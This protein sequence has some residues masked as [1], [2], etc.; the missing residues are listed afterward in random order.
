MVNNCIVLLNWYLWSSYLSPRK[1]IIDCITVHC[2]KNW[3]HNS[4][5]L[6]LPL[7]TFSFRV[8]GARMLSGGTVWVSPMYV[9]VY[10][11]ICVYIYIFIYVYIYKYIYIYIYIY[12]H[13]H[14]YI[15]IYIHIYI[16]ITLSTYYKYKYC[17]TYIGPS[18]SSRR[19]TKLQNYTVKS[20]EKWCQFQLLLDFTVKKIEFNV[21]RLN[22][23]WK[24]PM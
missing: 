24:G 4:H 21:P 16:S 1:L 5:F 15:Y 20:S 17:D 9:Y 19:H 7:V 13:I 22:R 12:I 10:V 11:Y 8:Q 3:L 6:I 18:L 2:F 23:W 14:T